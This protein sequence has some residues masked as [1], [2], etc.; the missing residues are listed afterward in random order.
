MQARDGW[1]LIPLECRESQSG[2]IRGWRTAERIWCWDGAFGYVGSDAGTIRQILSEDFLALLSPEEKRFLELRPV[3]RKGS[4]RKFFELLGPAGPPFVAVAG[5]KISGWHCTQC[6]HRTWGYWADGL[7]IQSFIAAP[8]LQPGL[9]GIFTVG[10]LPEVQLAVTAGRWKELVGK[11]GTRG[12]V[13]RLLGVVPQHEVIRIPELPT[14]EE[15]LRK[16][17]DRINRR[18]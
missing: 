8:D 2:R 11:R 1:K 6:D 18:T 4:G 14:S 12:F 3:K 5:L 16:S 10:L 7:A 15:R 13:S 17:A 9:N